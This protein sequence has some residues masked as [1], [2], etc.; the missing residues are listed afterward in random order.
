M[1]DQM[2]P[3]SDLD[4]LPPHI[5]AAIEA[6]QARAEEFS[7]AAGKTMEE[8]RRRQVRWASVLCNCSPWYRRDDPIPHDGC[9]VHGGFW[10]SDDGKVCL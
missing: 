6:Q 9:L 7:K 8:N 10:I 3:I 2:M 4:S 1:E 5:K